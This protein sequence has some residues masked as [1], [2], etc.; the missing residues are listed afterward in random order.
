V[1]SAVARDAA[2]NS[3]TSA[4]VSVSFNNTTGGAAPLLHVNSANSHQLLDSNNQPFY[5]V[6]DT[7]WSLALSLTEADA[8]FYFQTRAAQGFNTVLMDAVGLS[9][10]T[11]GSSTDRDGNAPFNGFLPGTSTYDVSTVPAAGDT[12]TSAG[13]YWQHV[14]NLIDMAASNGIEV[15]FNVYDTYSP[16]FQTSGRDGNSPSS[17]AKLQAYGEFLGQRYLNRSNIIWMFGNDYLVTSAGNADMAAVIQGIRQF[18]T[19][20]LITLE[21]DQAAG[22]PAAA[23]DNATLRQYTTL[24]GI[25]LYN[26]GPYRSTYLAQYN[27]ADVG[28]TFNDE[29]GYENNTGIG[30]TPATVRFGHYVFLLSGA[31]GDLYGNER[32]GGAFSGGP[33]AADWKTQ[34]NSQGAQEMTHFTSLLNSIPWHKLVPDQTGTVFQ[35]VGSPADYSGAYSLDGTLGVAYRPAAGGASQ[36]L[37][38]N[39]SKFSG[40]VTARWFDPSSG[41]YVSIAG[42]PFANAGSNTFITPGGNSVGNGD[43]VLVLE[44]IP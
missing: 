28:P 14:D 4:P 17:M 2:G 23:F 5:M 26:T 3:A 41:L 1:L 15:L 18:D 30:S 9:F 42:S 7:A 33:F 13:R 27:R 16:W 22:F 31:I 12:A 11:T 38:V 20:H 10:I 6:G 43:W 40:F 39:M 36:S 37:T 32:V 35:G 29:T 8:S 24:N 21:M 19:V 44:V 25:Y 34:L